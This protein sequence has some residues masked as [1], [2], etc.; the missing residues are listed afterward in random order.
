ML[1]VIIIVACV[2]FVALTGMGGYTMI[3]RRR[4]RR[5]LTGPPRGPSRPSAPPGPQPPAQ[6][7]A[8]K[9]PAGQHPAGQHPASQHPA[10]QHLAGEHPSVAPAPRAKPDLALERATVAEQAPQVLERPRFRDRL[11]K[12]RSLLAD[13]LAGVRRRGKIDKQAWDELEEALVLADV[14][15]T[16]TDE[17]LKDLKEGARRDGLNTPEQLVDALRE[18]L[19][20]RLQGERELHRAAVGMAT[21]WLFVG[22]NGVGKTTTIGKV[23]MRE[24]S[25]G[26][27]V[28]L[29]AGDTFRAAAADQLEP[30]SCGATKEATRGLSSSMPCSMRT[31]GT[32]LWCWPT[33]PAGC[34]T[35]ST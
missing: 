30:A 35:R 24:E 11:G 6:R 29:A 28:V 8:G 20:G 4:E 3:A 27:R 17:L 21:V 10:G 26:R 23:A 33:L 32:S 34:T 31:P 18:E 5:A 25:E 19:I 1:L 2:A 9:D 14:G 13:Q 12:A 15:I 7:P 22:V 16:T